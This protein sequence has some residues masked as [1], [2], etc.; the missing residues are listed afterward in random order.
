MSSIAYSRIIAATPD[1]VYTASQQYPGEWDPFSRIPRGS[2]PKQGARVGERVHIVAWHGLAMNVE[3]IQAQAPERAAMKMVAGPCFLE[4]FAG[5]WRFLPHG[6]DATLAHFNYYLR[7]AQGYRWLAPLMRF[8][9]AWE[10]RRRL[11]ALAHYCENS[12]VTIKDK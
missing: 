7:A 9:F 11:N 2:P 4:T 1:K 3:Y 8:Y 12:T 10:T 6:Q 5:T